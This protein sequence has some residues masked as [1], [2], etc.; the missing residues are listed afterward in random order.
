MQASCWCRPPYTIDEKCLDTDPILEFGFI[1]FRNGVTANISSENNVNGL[2]IA[3]SGT[4][5]TMRIPANGSHLE[6]NNR[7]VDVPITMS[8]TRRA[9]AQLARAVRTDG[10]SPISTAVVQVGHE[11]LFAFVKSSINEG[12]RTS[13][14]GLDDQFVITV[15]QGDLY[16]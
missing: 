5:G 2:N 8:G 16:P 7:F 10:P 14:N 13:L 4:K 15:K 3:I 11:I 1:K 6:V 9:Y 12:R